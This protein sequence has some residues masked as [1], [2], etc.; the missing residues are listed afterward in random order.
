[1]AITGAE[2]A[3]LGLEQLTG[4]RHVADSDREASIHKKKRG[5][6]SQPQHGVGCVFLSEISQQQVEDIVLGAGA[7]HALVQRAADQ[8]RIVNDYER[9]VIAHVLVLGVVLA[10]IPQIYLK[11]ICFLFI[12]FVHLK[13][14][15]IN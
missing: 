3:S 8:L 9:V 15:I 7:E 11:E 5:K 6:P 1:M 2:Q 4:R 10:F 12:F 14:I 13:L